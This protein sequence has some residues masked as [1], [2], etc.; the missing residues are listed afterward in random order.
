MT[1]KVAVWVSF[2]AHPVRVVVHAWIVY[3]PGDTSGTTKFSVTRPALFVLLVP[4]CL[5][6]PAGSQVSTKGLT[7]K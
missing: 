7:G 2:L 4:S 5:L 1:T 6:L 3:L